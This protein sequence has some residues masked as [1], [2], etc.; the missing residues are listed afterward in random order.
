MNK[1]YKAFFVL[2]LIFVAAL[3]S[4]WQETSSVTQRTTVSDSKLELQQESEDNEE[5]AEENKERIASLSEE[6]ERM[7]KKYTSLFDSLVDTEDELKT[8][9]EELEPKC[10]TFEEDVERRISTANQVFVTMPAKASGTSME[11]FGRRCTN[12][13]YPD[14]FIND[15]NGEVIKNFLLSGLDLPKL[16]VSH[17]Y[18]VDPLIR[19]V[20]TTPNDVL[21]IFL[22]REESDREVSAIKEVVDRYCY[23]N[24]RGSVDVTTLYPMTK[25]ETHCIVESEVDLINNLIERNLFEIS[26]DTESLLS[27]SLYD[28][29]DSNKPNMLMVNYKHANKLHEVLAKSLCP[30]VLDDLPIRSNDANQKRDWIYV[31]S[32]KTG[33]LVPLDKWAKSKKQFWNWAFDD[34]SGKKRC[35]ARTRELEKRMFSCE[36]QVADM[37]E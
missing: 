2:I 32:Q 31:R 3:Y 14:D 26:C 36:D 4:L 5:K 28:A 23:E 19:L 22:Y 37:S 15:P 13:D 35:R 6:L 8:K 24:K 30:E 34:K 9:K 20:E 11:E 18:R 21:N 33:E 25:N 12:F 16:I 1:Y 29:I 7:E 10:L 17:L 27:C